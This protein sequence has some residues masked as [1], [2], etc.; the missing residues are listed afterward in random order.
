MGA[1]ISAF[2]NAG[3]TY[4]SAAK[5]REARKVAT[6]K[7]AKELR[8]QQV[9]FVDETNRLAKPGGVSFEELRPRTVFYWEGSPDHLRI[10]LDRGDCHLVICPNG[11]II[12]NHNCTG[13][14]DYAACVPLPNFKL[15]MTLSFV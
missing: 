14:Y 3:G 9:E 2:V 1:D 7:M 11:D 13:E 15:T 10:K 12:T 6:E 8:R 4:P 5:D